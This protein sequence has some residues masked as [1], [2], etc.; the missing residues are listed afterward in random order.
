MGLGIMTYCLPRRAINSG[1]D[2][3]RLMRKLDIARI[4]E[5]GM[6]VLTQR[7]SRAA[8]R[9]LSANGLQAQLRAV[10]LLALAAAGSR[11]AIWTERA[12]LEMRSRELVFALLW[13]VGGARAIGAAWQAKHHRFAALILMGGAGLVTCATFV[14]LSALDL[15]DAIAGRDRDHH[16]AASGSALPPKRDEEIAGDRNM[17]ARIR[18]FRDLLI[19]P[20]APA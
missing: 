13:I 4:Y 18:R 10:V 7:L 14:W 3:T 5:R 9:I 19:A 12:L 20:T 6:R 16:A 17:P 1:E 11:C 2:G 15:A 8:L